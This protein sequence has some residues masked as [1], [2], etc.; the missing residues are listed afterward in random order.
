M[1]RFVYF[2]ALQQTKKSEKPFNE[3]ANQV[4]ADTWLTQA[5]SDIQKTIFLVYE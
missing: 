2:F 3:H 5:N 4:S 1:T